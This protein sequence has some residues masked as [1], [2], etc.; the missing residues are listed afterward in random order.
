[1]NVPTRFKGYPLVVSPGAG[2]NLIFVDARR[3]RRGR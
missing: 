3:D 1:M 2:A